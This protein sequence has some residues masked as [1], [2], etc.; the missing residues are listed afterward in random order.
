MVR[1]L[2]P[3]A[4]CM[5]ES[6]RASWMPSQN[7]PQTSHGWSLSSMTKL[8]SMAFQLS[9][10]SREVTIQPSSFHILAPSERLLNRPMAEP[11]LPKVEQL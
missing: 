7:E 11:F 6:R 9:R 1:G 3:R 8:G 2:T 4:M 5:V 10:F